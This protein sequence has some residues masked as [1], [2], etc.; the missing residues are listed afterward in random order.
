[1]HY[2]DKNI[3][4]YYIMSKIPKKYVSGL[5]EKDKEKQKKAIK[6]SREDYKKGKYTDRP[7][8]KSYENKR[9]SWVI[10]YE[11]KYK[12]KITNLDYIYKNILDKRYTDKI[13]SKGK[14]A[15]FSQGSRPNQSPS[16]WAYA[17]LASVIMGG[18]ARQIDKDLWKHNKLK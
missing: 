5:S 6:K 13:I 18:K 1:M 8:L 14:G 9:S 2:H 17:R 15:F 3:F 11:N 10:K 16:S 4:I 12:R 7:K